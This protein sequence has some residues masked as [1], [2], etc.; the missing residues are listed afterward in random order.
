VVDR[1]AL[2]RVR[3]EARALHGNLSA[4]PRSPAD[5]ASDAASGAGSGTGS[6]GL[7]LALAYP[8]RIAQ[9]RPGQ[10]GRFLLRNG[11]G[12][13][14]ES[15][16]LAGCDY[17]VAADLDGRR[18]ESR[19]FL[20]VPVT[21]EEVESSFGGQLEREDVVEWDP[22]AQA[23]VARRRVRLGALVLR[24]SPLR[25]PDPERLAGVL[26]DAIAREGLQLLPW[27]A[28]ATAV[29]QR[30]ECLRRL[31]ASWPDLSDTALTASLAGW[32]G[33]HLGGIRKRDELTRLDLAGILLDTLPWSQRAAL[34]RLAPTHLKVPSGSRIPI[35]YSDPAAPVLAVR[36]QEVFGLTD[37]PRIAQ[38]A[39][40]LTLHLLSPARRPVQVTRDLAGFWKTTYFEVKKDLKGRYPKHYWPDDPLQAIPTRHARPRS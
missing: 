26:L 35:D 19:I 34:E 28:A 11:Q 12:A 7:L 6:E 2:R 8:D 16:A 36:L 21:I 32:L 31:D 25:M 20:A 40:P 5:A 23:V 22:A 3:D 27:G 38:G 17:L 1:D 4:G 29:R 39:I 14:V 33:P 13:S 30:I 18:R 24:D 9:R 15:P 37:T 10:A